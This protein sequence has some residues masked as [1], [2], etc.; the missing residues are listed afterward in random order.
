MS[1]PLFF[2]PN[3]DEEISEI[4]LN[5]NIINISN[6]YSHKI[7]LVGGLNLS[8]K[9]ARQLVLLLPIYG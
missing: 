9:Y 3:E 1:K 5:N 7:I 6:M 4:R 2:N 8:E